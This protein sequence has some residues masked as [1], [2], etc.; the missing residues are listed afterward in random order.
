MVSY[1]WSPSVALS[2]LSDTTVSLFAVT[3]ETQE[4][5][6]KRCPGSVIGMYLARLT[7]CVPPPNRLLRNW[8]R[9]PCDRMA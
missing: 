3:R 4:L 9:L 8:R 1:R 2:A 5:T 6:N 7:C